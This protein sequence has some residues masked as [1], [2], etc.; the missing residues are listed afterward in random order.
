MRQNSLFFAAIVLIA[1]LMGKIGSNDSGEFL[2]Q[3]EIR[4]TS[5]SSARSSIA[6]G[7][8]ITQTPPLN[9]RQAIQSPPKDPPAINASAA[10]AKDFL[11][12]FT[13]FE[14]NTGARWP[15]A[16]LTKLMTAVVAAEKVGL[17]K[18]V[19]VSSSSVATEG[20]A[21]NFSAG[22]IFTAGD[23]L[24]SLMAVSSNDAAAAIAEYY[25]INRFIEEMN[26]KAAAIGMSQTV[27]SDPAGLS[28]LNQSTAGDLEKLV[29]YIFENHPLI[30]AASRQKEIEIIEQSSKMKRKLLN[31][32]QFAGRDDFLGGKTGFT[33]EAGGNL[34]SVFEHQN[35]PLLVI[36]FGTEDRFA[37]TEKIYDWILGN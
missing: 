15:L 35:R 28:P 12:Q 3:K 34:I 23:L 24:R 32:N 7:F 5:V 22:E 16:S 25:G 31:I 19:L 30:F 1:V 11:N 21:G 4:E 27:F 36:V 2:L 9:Y 33:E 10:L 20:V 26:V 13:Y 29:S 14:I 17:E 18:L 6:A 8:A 37:E